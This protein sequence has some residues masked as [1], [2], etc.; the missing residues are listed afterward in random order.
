MRCMVLYVVLSIVVVVLRSGEI[1]SVEKVDV[2][3]FRMSCRGDVVCIGSCVY[4]RFG[5]AI[6]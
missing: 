6:K 4:G 1:S 5:E 2:V 3:M